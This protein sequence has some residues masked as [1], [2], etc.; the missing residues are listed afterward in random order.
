[1]KMNLIEADKRQ[2]ES[3]IA[4]WFIERNLSDDDLREIIRVCKSHLETCK[5]NKAKAFYKFKMRI[6]QDFLNYGG[7]QRDLHYFY[8]FQNEI[9][10][11]QKRAREF[12]EVARARWSAK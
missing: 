1:M 9:L 10:K 3:L 5:E 2:L 6:A 8:A 11:A 12:V 7:I 4:Q